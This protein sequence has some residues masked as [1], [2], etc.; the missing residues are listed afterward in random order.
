[1]VNIPTGFG[2]WL[3][4]KLPQLPSSPTLNTVYVEWQMILCPKDPQRGFQDYKQQ[5]RLILI[6]HRQEFRVAQHQIWYIWYLIGCIS[7]WSQNGLVRSN[8]EDFPI[9]AFPIAARVVL[10]SP[11]FLDNELFNPAKSGHFVRKTS[12][13]QLKRW[14]NHKLCICYHFLRTHSIFLGTSKKRSKP[15]IFQENR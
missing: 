12:S 9:I 1:M 5:Q 6:V 4:Q 11:A 7:E 14:E 10:G 13:K 2:H 8:P 15:M 3:V